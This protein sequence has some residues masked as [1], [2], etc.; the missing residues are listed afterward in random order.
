[1]STSE[2]CTFAYLA[3]QAGNNGFYVSTQNTVYTIHYDRNDKSKLENFEEI[4][5]S[6]AEGDLFIPEIRMTAREKSPE[7]KRLP[8]SL[9]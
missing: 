4:N 8:L 3:E 6:G 2:I 9:K 5:D 1:M 7:I